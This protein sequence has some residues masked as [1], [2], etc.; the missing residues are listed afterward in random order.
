MQAHGETSE[1]SQ[2][3]IIRN[4]QRQVSELT[5]ANLQLQEQQTRREQ[6]IAMIAHDLR[7]PLTPIINYAQML[8]RHTCT[9][10]TGNDPASGQGPKSVQIQRQ[11]SI[12]IS[13]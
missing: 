2:E 12:I 4:L 7:G 1:Q 6:F 13:Q 3:E 10:P 5:E 9:L 11:T 8:A